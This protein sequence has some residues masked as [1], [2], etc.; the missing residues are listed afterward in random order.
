MKVSNVRSVGR[1]A[2]V[3]AL[4]FTV[5]ALGAL[6]AGAS[7][8]APATARCYCP[9]GVGSGPATETAPGGYSAVVTSRTIT[10]SGGAIGEVSVPG[11]RVTLVIPAGAFPVP[12]QIT[13]TAPR[14]AALGGARLTGYR[15]VT[16]VGIAVQEN[17][18]A[19]PGTFRKPLTLTM[20]SL[21]AMSSSLVAVWTGKTFVTEPDATVARGAATVRFRLDT[22][23]D[24]AV[25]SPAVTAAPAA[26]TGATTSMTGEPFIGEG[27][28][29][30][31]L[32][33][34]GVAGLVMAIRSS[35]R[36]TS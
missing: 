27:I 32:L 4:L 34:L 2:A 15:I 22:D 24:F 5:A 35:R 8:R 6:P 9:S 21:S 30:A 11:G 26:I 14:L 23:P 28:L 36:A 1:L 19:Y 25:L 10:S 20:R 13:L 17:G 12:V 29:A 16:G 3:S 31:V 33:A 7:V 18:V